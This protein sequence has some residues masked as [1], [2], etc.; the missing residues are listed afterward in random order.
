LEEDRGRLDWSYQGSGA[1]NLSEQQAMIVAVAEIGEALREIASALPAVRTSTGTD[2]M[3]NFR[4]PE[5]LP[6]AIDAWI[7]SQSEPRPSRS[8]AIRR[9]LAEAL[10]KP[11]ET[12]DVTAA[13][14][15]CG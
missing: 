9:L 10:G 14:L 5:A 11:V 2:P 12:D 6:A 13:G 8:E 1:T 4:S 3:L 7:A 15:A